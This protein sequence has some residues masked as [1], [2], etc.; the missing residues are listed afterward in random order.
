[1]LQWEESFCFVSSVAWEVQVKTTV[2]TRDL[3]K[4]KDSCQQ[5]ALEAKDEQTPPSRKWGANKTVIAASCNSFFSYKWLESFPKYNGYS[6]GSHIF[7]ESLVH[8]S[9]QIENTACFTHRTVK[10]PQ[11]DLHGVEAL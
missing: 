2:Y 4:D 9:D 3:L 8:L 5:I 7:Q 6:L 1:M 10:D 11:R